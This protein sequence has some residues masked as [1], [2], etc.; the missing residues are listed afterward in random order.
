MDTHRAWACALAL[1]LFVAAAE[2]V[3][4]PRPGTPAPTPALD[5]ALPAGQRVTARWELPADRSGATVVVAQTTR[6]QAGTADE[7][8]CVVATLA[9]G[10][11]QVTSAPAALEASPA[12]CLSAARLDNQWVFGRWTLGG[13][14][15]GAQR[16]NESGLE[17]FAFVGGRLQSVW[18]GAVRAFGLLTGGAVVDLT[19]ITPRPT[20]LV[21]NADRTRLVPRPRTPPRR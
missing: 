3:A 10:A 11:W 2:A 21:W 14:G 19:G 13:Y 17:L 7:L 1:P 4:Q 12:D 15:D 18:T 9:G 5:Q 16:V 6:S 8:A 20:L